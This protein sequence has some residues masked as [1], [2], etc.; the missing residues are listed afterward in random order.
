[1]DSLPPDDA[2]ERVTNPQRYG[3]VVE[4]ARALIDR[5]VRDFDAEVVP[6]SVDADFPQDQRGSDDEVVRVI[7]RGPGGPL[8]F[9]ITE[10]PGVIVRFGRLHEEPFPGCGCDACDEHPE[11]LVNTLEELVGTYVAGGY[12]EE[13]TRRSS[14][15]SFVGPWGSSSGTTMLKRSDWKQL[16]SLGRTVWLPWRARTPGGDG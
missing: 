13:L 6:G 8:T 10:F 15:Y 16:G 5:L 4:A 7:P 2:Y 1:M 9:R 11:D 3:V 14:R 12:I